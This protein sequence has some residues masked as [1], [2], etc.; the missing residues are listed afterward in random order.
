MKTFGLTLAAGLLL[1]FAARQSQA[2]I[3]IGNPYNGQGVTIGPNGVSPAY[4]YNN[5]AYGNYGAYGAPGTNYY[6]SGYRAPGVMPQNGY[7]NGNMYRGYGTAT[8]GYPMRRGRVY[9]YPGSTTTYR[10][11]VF[12]RQ[13]AR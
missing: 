10:R 4:G 2:Q 5:G 9:T 11:G 13:R 3:T 6:N 1:T 12:G 7:Y 8:N